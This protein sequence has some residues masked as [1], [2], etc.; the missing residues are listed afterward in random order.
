[1]SKSVEKINKSTKN[2]KVLKETNLYEDLEKDLELELELEK[3][4]T[5]QL[6][7]KEYQ[8]PQ[9]VIKSV[10]KNKNK[11]LPWSEKYRP[12]SVSNIIY[13]DKITKAIINYMDNIIIVS[14]L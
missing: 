8:I 14:I 2:K 7:I 13:H 3:E 6:Y 11:N 10:V 4:K 5:K 1:M 9:P 12:S